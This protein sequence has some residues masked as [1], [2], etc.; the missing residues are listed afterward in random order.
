LVSPEEW[1]FQF[2]CYPASPSRR[3]E[4][5]EKKARIVFLSYARLFEPSARSCCREAG[6]E[7]DQRRRLGTSVE[8]YP[9]D[10]GQGVVRISS[11]V[12]SHS[13]H[14]RGDRCRRLHK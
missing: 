12:N 5:Q 4:S 1:K 8:D 10:V 13:E 2:Q 11:D 7:Q 14:H 3:A 9:A 6:A